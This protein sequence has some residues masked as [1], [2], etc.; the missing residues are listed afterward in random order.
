[1]LIGNVANWLLFYFSDRLGANPGLV[2]LWEDEKLRR[3]NRNLS[4]ALA[5][6]DSPGNIICR[7][8]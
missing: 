3:S 4:S 7:V 2:A 6:P 1:M 5:P 8:Q